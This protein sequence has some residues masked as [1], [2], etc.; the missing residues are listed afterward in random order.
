MVILKEIKRKRELRGLDDRLVQERI[1]AYLQHHPETERL[2]ASRT[3]KEFLRSQRFKDMKSAVRAELREIYGVFDLDEK[4]RREH[5]LQGLA[6]QK[7][8]SIVRELL[9]LHQSSKERLH[10]YARLYPLL[11]EHT[12]VP[13]RILD[14]GCGANP[15]SYPLLGCAPQ[16]TAVDL[17]SDDLTA[18]DRFFAIMGIAG[19]TLGVDLVTEQER[20]GQLTQE[21][22]FDVVFL[23]KLLDSLETRERHSSKRLLISLKAPWLI[24]SFPTRSIGGG[25]PIG[26]ERR[27]WFEKFIAKQG[28]MYEQILLSNE[29]FYVID[30][31]LL[32]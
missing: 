3:V 6:A 15:Y 19:M 16:Y 14:L 8:E 7:D 4:G 32:R 26:R 30:T 11:W 25:R 9:Q 2:M 31:R 27:S 23:F 29:V 20:V 10:E 21:E 13:R 5:L 17:P 28:W 1:D 24:V 22:D 12:G 18:I